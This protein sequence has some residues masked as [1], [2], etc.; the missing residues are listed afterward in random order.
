MNGAGNFFS[1]TRIATPYTAKVISNGETRA[2]VAAQ[3]GGDCNT[4]HTERGSSDARARAPSPQSPE[5]ATDRRPH[6]HHH[7][8]SKGTMTLTSNLRPMSA[9]ALLGLFAIAS[10][11]GSSAAVGDD[12]VGTDAGTP[13]DGGRL[14]AAD[15]GGD[16]GQRDSGSTSTDAGSSAGGIKTVFVIVMENHSWATIKNAGASATY[17]NQ[18]LLSMGAHAEQYFTPPG[19]HPSEPNYIWLEAGDSLG[20]D[21]DG[22]PADNHQATTDHLVAQLEKK[23]LT[24]R[25]YAEDI[26]GDDCPLEKVKSY[27][28]KHTPQVYFD[29]VT[30]TNDPSS[31]KCKEHVRPFTEL[32]QDLQAN[33]VA[34]YNFITP[35]LCNDMHGELNLTCNFI[36]TDRIKKGDDW[37]RTNIPTILASDAYKQ[38]GVVFVAWDEG[39]ESLGQDASDGPIPLFVLSPLAKPGYSSNT[40]FTHSS[41]LRTIET[42]F[43]VPYLRGAQSSNDL[44]E[45]FTSFP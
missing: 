18:T 43:G 4:C 1:K 27:D 5:P 2:M 31:A 14:P 12:D 19:L 9:L 44:S 33:T 23:G 13:R 29:D 11:C 7:P 35:N 39:D 34:R 42:I 37:L 38:N 22:P 8:S 36:T 17:I 40:T 6:I 20:I 25:S 45:M 10:A 26:G 41:L 30:D 28:P 21:D 16:G 24:W 15:S 3:T 32:A